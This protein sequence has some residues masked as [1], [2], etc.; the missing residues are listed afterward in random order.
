MIFFIFFA[1]IVKK[2]HILDITYTEDMY[3]KKIKPFEKLEFYED[4]MFGLVM[5]DKSL[6]REVLECLLGIKIRHLEYAEP[7]KHFKPM[8]TARGIRLDVY[9]KHGNTLVYCNK[10]MP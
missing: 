3:M 8:Y 10:D 4:F 9:V 7:Q 2:M 5:Q 6:C 1:E